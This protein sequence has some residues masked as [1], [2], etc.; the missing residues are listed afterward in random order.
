MGYLTQITEAIYVTPIVPWSKIKD[1]PFRPECFNEKNWRT[2]V[3]D[4]QEEEV[5]TDEG[6][7]TRKIATRIICG[8]QDQLK[9]YHA[10]EHL[11]ELVDHLGPDFAYS[12]RF[13]GYGEENGDMWRLHVR[14][15]KVV[16]TEPSIVW[17]DGP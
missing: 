12:G 7:L 1:T 5:E 13:E 2:F 10:E 14:N 11:Q 16:K 6:T 3:F 17:P 9:A 4:V 8:T 15:G